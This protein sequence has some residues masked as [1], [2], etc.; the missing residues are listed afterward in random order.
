MFDAGLEFSRWLL[1]WL[2][3]DWQTALA[4]PLLIGLLLVAVMVIVRL[5]P[6]VDRVIGPLGSGLATLLGMVVL[7]PEYLCTV[8][9]RRCGR[10]PPGFFHTYGDAVMGLVLLG[11]RVSRAGLTGFTSSSGVRKLLILTAVGVIV[12]A[13]NA[14]SCPSQAARCNPPLK[15]WW[16]QTKTIFV[17]EPPTPPKPKTTKKPTKKP[18]P[19]KTS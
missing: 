18:T 3:A 15:A 2:D 4:V 1:S 17:D 9:L 19:Q 12:V 10:A 14:Q 6:V 13:G 7:L 11:H 8:V 5:L 16:N